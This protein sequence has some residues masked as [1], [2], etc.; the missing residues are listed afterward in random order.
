M[1]MIH[2]L[3]LLGGHNNALV[4][5]FLLPA[6]LFLFQLPAAVHATAVGTATVTVNSNS[7]IN[8][9]VNGNVSGNN[10]AAAVPTMKRMKS[11]SKKS[12]SSATMNGIKSSAA[13]ALAAGCSKALLAPFDTIKTMQ[14]QAVAQSSG[15]AKGLSLVQAAKLVCSRPGGFL[16]L[17]A[18]LG[19]A[20]VGAMPS[21]GLYFG[22]YAYAKD[23]LTP[24][25]QRTLCDENENNDTNI[26]GNI[27]MNGNING[28]TCASNG[29]G[30]GNGNKN[31]FKFGFKYKCMTKSQARSLSIA[32]SAAIGNT[33]ASFSRVPHEVVKQKLQTAEYS[34]TVEAL[35]HL[36]NS[37]G[38]R[39]FFPMGGVSI[40]MI[41]DIPYAI[42][43]LMTYEYLREHWV[44]ANRDT[45][46]VNNANMSS[47]SSSSGPKRAKPWRDMVAGGFSGGCGSFFTNPMDVIK[48]RLQIN[49]TEYDG[50]VWVCAKRTFEEGGGGAFLRGSVPRLIHKVPANA[51]FFVFYEFFCRTLGVGVDGNGDGDGNGNE[52]VD[53]GDGKKTD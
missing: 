31:G 41:R 8:G 35:S 20:V 28:D 22:V 44:N 7:Y 17:Y 36:W 46:S 10:N 1:R 34:S 30:N 37:G 21:V 2:V 24:I 43:T 11:R 16:E 42:V 14:Q 39:A 25:F 51:F 13:S 48:T 19:V 33:V 49:P 47:S 38:M 9:N 45:G 29:N 50:N 23:K 15:A 18:G 26:D 53:G 4:L 6:I 5:L 40:Q 32:T 12:S 52:I 3:Q 27:N